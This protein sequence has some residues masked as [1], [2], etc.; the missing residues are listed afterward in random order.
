MNLDHS[1]ESYVSTHASH[2]RNTLSLC[3]LAIAMVGFSKSFNTYDIASEYIMKS[4]GIL[5]F[6]YGFIYGLKTNFDF[7][8][9]LDELKTRDNLTAFYHQ[10]ISRWQ[11]WIYMHYTFISF[12]VVVVLLIS[13]KFRNQIKKKY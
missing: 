13:L 3:S 11:Q 12:L 9:Y 10:Q 1:P 6:I 4:F 5:I 7:Q 2:V 8:S